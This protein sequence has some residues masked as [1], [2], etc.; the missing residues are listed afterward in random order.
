MLTIVLTQSLSS[1]LMAQAA[2]VTHSNNVNDEGNG[3]TYVQSLS[4]ISEITTTAAS[5]T[6]TTTTP[7]KTF[8]TDGNGGA[9]GST[10]KT[11]RQR[12]PAYFLIVGSLFLIPGLFLLW[13]LFVV[14]LVLPGRVPNF[15]YRSVVSSSAANSSKAERKT[16][17]QKHQVTAQ[18]IDADA[19]QNI[20]TN[21][22]INTTTTTAQ[23]EEATVLTA[24]IP[25]AAAPPAYSYPASSPVLPTT[26]YP[27]AN[28]NIK[29]G[30]L[31][32]EAAD[33]SSDAFGSS[34][35]TP[36]INSTA[37]SQKLKADPTSM[38][39]AGAGAASSVWSPL[40]LPSLA[41]SKAK[42]IAS[43]NPG[44]TQNLIAGLG[45]NLVQPI[46]YSIPF[47]AAVPA[48]TH[49]N[50]PVPVSNE[51]ERRTPS[52][53]PPLLIE[54]TPSPAIT[55]LSKAKTTTT[56]PPYLQKLDE[57]EAILDGDSDEPP[58]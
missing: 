25:P 27:K 42:D 24:P 52:L 34:L 53:P 21:P 28:S 7:G 8:T 9:T 35:N 40:A 37:D 15:L 56:P 4:A 19:N 30:A 47:A 3:S 48:V 14:R 32:G 22:G 29:A 55:F 23:T 38:T 16:R 49:Q 10:L 43:V 54:V 26:K 39:A 20:I 58:L 36:T 44:T 6:I 31:L 18:S 5:T 12:D 1:P 33:G 57:L 11:Y 2:T 13:H 51:N 46:G 41:S 17:R 50:A 45:L